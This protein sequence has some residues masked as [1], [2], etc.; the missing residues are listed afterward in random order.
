MKGVAVFAYKITEPV[1]HGHFV[2]LSTDDASTTFSLSASQAKHPPESH[3]CCHSMNEAPVFWD[4]T[5]LKHSVRDEQDTVDD[6]TQESHIKHQHSYSIKNVQ[7]LEGGDALSLDTEHS[8]WIVKPH[9]HSH[10]HSYAV[11]ELESQHSLSFRTRI[12]KSNQDAIKDVGKYFPRLL[13]N[14][15]RQRDQ[16]KND[17]WIVCIGEMILELNDTSRDEE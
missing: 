11:A 13:S 6:M 4:I 14:D 9:D 8:D 16:D 3:P 1:L 5:L 2:S 15:T 7:Q 10:S 12:L 17:D